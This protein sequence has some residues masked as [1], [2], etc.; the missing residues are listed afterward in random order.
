MMGAPIQGE[1]SPVP[2]VRLF[3]ESSLRR[4]EKIPLA[5]AQA[6]YVTR[7]MRLGPGDDLTLFNGRDGEWSARVAAVAK[8]HCLVSIEEQT[9]PPKTEP[10]LWLAFAPVK[11]AGTDFIV[12]KATELGASRL[13]PVLTRNTRTMRVNT[14]RLAANAVE[15]AEQCRRLCVPKVEEPVSLDRLVETWPEGRVLLVCHEKGGGTPVARALEKLPD[16]SGAL[17]VLVGPE[18]GF[19]ETELD[20]LAK[21]PFAVAVSLGPRILRTETAAVA[22]LAC[23]QALRGDWR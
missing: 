7:V 13:I 16:P 22:A 1:C 21:L 3:V 6:H 17:A 8:G 14:A 2:D 15:A 18:G 9:R 11:K 12:E 10:D 5:P 19:T 20:A 23:V 4:G